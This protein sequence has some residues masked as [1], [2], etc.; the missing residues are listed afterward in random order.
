MEF[1][2]QSP[3]ENTMLFFAIAHCTVHVAK[4]HHHDPRRLFYFQ[5][6]PQP[7]LAGLYRKPRDF[8]A[9]AIL[10]RMVSILPRPRS[11]LAERT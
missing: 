11:P 9:N 4:L 7:I 10:L 3:Q 2:R 1:Q 8:V 6:D 5:I